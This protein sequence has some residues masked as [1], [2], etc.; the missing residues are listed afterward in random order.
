MSYTAVIIDDEWMGR[1]VLR[2]KIKSHLPMVQIVG[3]AENGGEGKKMIDSLQPAIVFLDIEMPDMTG[4]E[5]IDQLDFKD[6][7]LIF[8]T[9]YDQYAIKAFK[10]GAIDYLLKPID[11]VELVTLF[12]KVKVESSQTKFLWKSHD[13]TLISEYLKVL[14]R[15][16]SKIAVPD[17]SGITFVD[18]DD[19]VYLKA[20]NNYT[21]ITRKADKAIVSSK[22]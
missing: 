13:L 10:Y 11:I 2:E 16:T 8:T 15:K 12:N 14:N 22:L 7:S 5:M 3:E 4:F 20:D 21:I 1:T 19:M 9:A 17:M 18:L 6:F